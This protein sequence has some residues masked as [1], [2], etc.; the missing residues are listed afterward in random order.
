MQRVRSGGC[1]REAA[2]RGGLQLSLRREVS[3]PQ[4]L[5]Q[6]APG[7][8]N[9]RRFQ[10][11]IAAAGTARN[12]NSRSYVTRIRLR[13]ENSIVATGDLS[14]LRIFTCPFL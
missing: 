4:P 3:V 2:L 9:T 6:N 13:A 8:A 1:E 7:N 5:P 14:P 11:L 12:F 10:T